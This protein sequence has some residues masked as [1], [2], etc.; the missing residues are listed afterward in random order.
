MKKKKGGRPSK[1]LKRELRVTVRFSRLEHYILQQKATKAGMNVSEFIRPAAIYGKVIARQTEEERHFTRQLAAKVK[2]LLAADISTRVLNRARSRCSEHRN[3]DFVKLDLSAELLPGDMDLICC[4][5][6]LY[7]LKD[8]VELELVAKKLLQA[9]RPGGHLIAAHAF[10]LS[11]N[12]SRTGF[13]W[14]NPYGAE[15]IAP[16]DGVTAQVGGTAA[17]GHD[18]LVAQGA[19]APWAVGLTLIA[20]AI[21]L[22]LLFGSLFIPLKAVLMTLLSISASF[23]ALVWIFQEGHLSGVLHFTPAPLDPSIPVL[24]FCIVFGL[25]MDYEV[26]LLSRM[27]EEYVRTGDNTRAVAGGLE[28]TGRLITSAAL[29]MV[30]VFASFATAHVTL[31]KAIG[32]GLALAVA[33]D[34][35]LV[36]ALVVPAAMRLMGDWNW[37]AP[38]WMR[39]GLAWARH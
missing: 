10:V 20:S 36:R 34:A 19:R 16:G 1:K 32:F 12:M 37:W 29:I 25:S 21:V 18:F 9:L 17:T 39:R 35:T 3:V 14:E 13:D 7:Y 31:I 28:R 38:R 15:T 33:V 22:F 11:D 6:V 2:H 26:L 30:L 5:E 23:G 27:H 8:E 24:L 4:S